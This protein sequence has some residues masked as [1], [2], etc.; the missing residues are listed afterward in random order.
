MKIYTNDEIMNFEMVLVGIILLT[1]MTA[2]SITLL[3]KRKRD[4]QNTMPESQDEVEPI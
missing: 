4:A 1:G 3:L 2:G